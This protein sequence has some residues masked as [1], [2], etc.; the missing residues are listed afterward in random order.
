MKFE[1]LPRDEAGDVVAEKIEF[2]VELGLLRPVEA[3]GRKLESLTL[4]E[5][6][7]ADIELCWKQGSDVAR[8]IYLLAFVAEL[9]PDEV[10]QLKAVDFTRASG[11]VG[12]FL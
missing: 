5:P 2:P 7:A 4:R 3:G 10:R 9:A 1:D 8:M 6:T 11:V 12:A